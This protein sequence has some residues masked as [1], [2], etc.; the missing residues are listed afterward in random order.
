MKSALLLCCVPLLAA[1]SALL[2]ADQP[3][4][5][6]LKATEGVSRPGL[7]RPKCDRLGRYLPQQC[8][9]SV[10]SCVSPSGETLS[11]GEGEYQT[12]IGGAAQQ[13]CR[14]ARVEFE[15]SHNKELGVGVSVSCDTKGDYHPV[16][17]LGSGCRCAH[18]HTGDKLQGEGL[19]G[20][21]A[22]YAQL[23]TRCRQAA[24]AALEQQ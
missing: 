15:R 6:A 24:A 23:E 8:R 13:A 2:G 19:E 4:W 14:C 16:Q 7:F 21:V 5:D 18:P 1:G 10:C 3:C 17:C 22:D 9:G 11:G 12:H 20:H